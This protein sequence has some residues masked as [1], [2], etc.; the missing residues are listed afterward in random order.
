MDAMNVV[1]RCCKRKEYMQKLLCWK[2]TEGI[3][4]DL[5]LPQ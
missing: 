3:C 5:K 1:N 4:P 2:S